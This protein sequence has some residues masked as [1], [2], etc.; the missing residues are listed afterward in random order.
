MDIRNGIRD[1]RNTRKAQAMRQPLST[2]LLRAYFARIVGLLDYICLIT[3]T[4]RDSAQHTSP[5]NRLLQEDDSQEYKDLLTR[6]LVGD[7]LTCKARIMQFNFATA[8]I[9]LSDVGAHS[10]YLVAPDTDHLC[11]VN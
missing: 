10:L 4:S 1:E 3:G 9:S 6:T 7:G 8:S 11:Q 5:L 2:V